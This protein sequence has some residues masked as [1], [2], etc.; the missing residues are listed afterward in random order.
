MGRYHHAHGYF[1][2]GLVDSE[3]RVKPAFFGLDGPADVSL[4]EGVDLGRVEVIVRAIP[5][6][7]DVGRFELGR[8]P[9]D[10]PKSVVALADDDLLGGAVQKIQ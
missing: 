1:V 9:T 2:D 4:L 6:A 5:G 3:A 8:P 7:L 10:I